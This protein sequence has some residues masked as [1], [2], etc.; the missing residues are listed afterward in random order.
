MN[1]M[2]Y[3]DGTGV[4]ASN[5]ELGCQ[6]R[7]CAF[8][9]P[10]NVKDWDLASTSRKPPPRNALHPSAFEGLGYGE[11]DF[12]YRH[13]PSKNR[14]NNR[15]ERRERNLIESPNSA[16][17]L[18]RSPSSTSASMSRRHSRS[19]SRPRGDEPPVA[20]PSAS[21][22]SPLDKNAPW[23]V[24]ASPAE[25]TGPRPLSPPP[26]LPQPPSFLDNNVP[27]LA[28]S[29]SLEDRRRAWTQRVE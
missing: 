23:M 18:D 24:S 11:S 28:N 20:G 26:P 3:A 1:Q 13:S 21:A 12:G 2:Y 25:P 4:M 5:G 27:Q 6:K 7:N 17:C 22:L 16:P 8:V 15:N 9:H 14:N 10:E 19:R 29:A